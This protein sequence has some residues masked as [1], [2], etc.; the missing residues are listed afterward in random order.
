MTIHFR[1]PRFLFQPM[2]KAFARMPAHPRGCDA[3]PGDAH[4]IGETCD[5]QLSSSWL[6]RSP[7]PRLENTDRA[8]THHSFRGPFSAVSTPIFATKYSFCSIFRDLQ[9]ELAEF[10]KFCQN[11]QKKSK[12]QENFAKNPRISLRFYR[13]CK[14]LQNFANFSK[15]QLA[16]FVD[17]EKCCKMSIWL[18]KSASIQ[19]RSSPL[20]LAKICEI[21]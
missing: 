1:I 10:S 11:F 17:L 15:I 14:I 6:R 20:K 18:Q 2:Q 4:A 5:E 16:H 12:I 19:P 8:T 3:G 13:I 21:C 9:N 7:L